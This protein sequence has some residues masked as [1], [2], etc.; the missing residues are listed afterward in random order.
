MLPLSLLRRGFAEGLA[1]MLLVAA[2]IG[3]GIMA[4]RLAP[5]DDALALLCNT[6]ATAGALVALILAFGGA[7]GAH[8]NPL[9]TIT[10]ALRGKQPWR[11]VPVY[12]LLQVVGAMLGAVLAHAMFAL[13]LVQESSKARNADGLWLSEVVATFALLLTIF[14]CERSDAKRTPFAVAAIITGAY[15]FTA[16]TSFA[17]PAVTIARSL[18]DT[19][20]GIRPTDVLGFV[21]AQCMGTALALLV[22][23]I[24]FGALAK[25]TP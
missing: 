6:L 13:P 20:A 10:M 25:E 14:G 9:V 7:S 16:S 17:N 8:M 18:T 24:L 2:V 1:T 22:D 5:R 21:G 23:R 12:A 4:S 15:W 3:S 19:F 11:E